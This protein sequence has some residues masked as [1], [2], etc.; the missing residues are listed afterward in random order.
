LAS[1]GGDGAQAIAGLGAVALVIGSIVLF[2]WFF[3]RFGMALPA[4]AVEGGVPIGRAWALSRGL[5]G[6]FA[7]IIVL[8]YLVL[9][10]V[11]MV[12]MM[13]VSMLTGIILGV[14]TGLGS[15]L[16]PYFVG[17]IIAAGYIAIY[18]FGTAFFIALFA[19]PYKRLT[20]EV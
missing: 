12:F 3:G 1:A 6:T 17:A 9:F 18:C 5:G 10:A 4:S 15:Q 8:G 13:A 2:L 20:Q 14:L 19:G 11:S 16:A 7:L